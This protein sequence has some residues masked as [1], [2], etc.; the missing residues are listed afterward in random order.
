VAAYLDGKRWRWR[1]QIRVRGQRIRGSGTPPVNTKRAAQ[2]DEHDW[3]EQQRLPVALRA[4]R[5][6]PTLAA[7][8]DDY[9]LHVKRH[10]SRSLADNRTSHLKANLVPFFGRTRL[11]RIDV[12]MVDRYKAARLKTDDSPEGLAASTVNQHL[13]ALS[14]L[15]RWAQKR[16]WLLDLP[17]IEHLPE[18][19]PEDR[20]EYLTPTEL[21]AVLAKAT[22]ELH[23]MVLIAARTGLRIGELLALKW[24]D[25]D[26]QAGRLTVRHGTYRGIDQPPK[27]RKTRTVPLSDAARQ[28]LRAHRHLRGPYVFCEDDGSRAHYTTHAARLRAV[29]VPGWH[30]LRHTFGTA[31]AARGVPLRAIQEW[32][33]HADIKTTMIYAHFSPVMDGSIAVLDAIETRQPGANAPAAPPKPGRK[34]RG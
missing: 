14:N 16:G 7:V 34:S 2:D 10:R 32:M 33:G 27:N 30:V 19:R 31:L 23:T 25:V 28:A 5:E 9:L 26:L 17:E 18:E 11:D 24:A 21:E 15:L 4:P 22:G 12:A 8:A 6:V 20:I 3:I 1:R 13:F 29:G